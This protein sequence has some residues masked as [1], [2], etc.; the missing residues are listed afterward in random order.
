MRSDVYTDKCIPRNVIV[1]LIGPNDDQ[2]QCSRRILPTLTR[3]PWA[4][5]LACLKSF[6]R[7]NVLFTKW[8]HALLLMMMRVCVTGCETWTTQEGVVSFSGNWYPYSSLSDCLQMCLEMSTCVAADFSFTLCVVHTNLNGAVTTN[9]GYT[10]YIPNR[11]CQ[12]PTRVNPSLATDT[13]T[14]STYTGNWNTAYSIWRKTA[15]NHAKRYFT[16]Q[17]IE[18]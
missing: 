7:Q 2:R 8:M 14:P 11:A 12:S 10:R 6:R 15:K 5:R 13:T 17:Q 4:V 18:I 1:M 9:S 16:R 3:I